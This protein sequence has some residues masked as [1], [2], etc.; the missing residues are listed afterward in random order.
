MKGMSGLDGLFLHLETPA[1]PMHV[2]A[3]Y[4]LEPPAG[5]VA[6][7]ADEL[8]RRL[9][10]RLAL[11]PF[12]RARLAPLPLHLANPLW[13]DGGIPDFARHLQRIVLPQPGGLAE[14]QDCAAALHATPLDRRHPLWELAIIDGLAG[15]EVAIYLKVHHA[16]VDGISGLG[17]AASIFDDSP[18]PS[19]VPVDWQ[20]LV[21][22]AERAGTGTRLLAALRQTAAQS[23][24]LLAQLPSGVRLLAGLVGRRG[25]RPTAGMRQN[26]G[27]GPRTPLNVPITAERDFAA[28]SLPL[29]GVR[30]IAERHA[31]TLNDVVLTLCSTAVR[32]YL[33]AHGGVPR[34][35]LLATMPVSLRDAGNTE[36]TI[37]A[38]LTLVRLATHVADPLRR[39]Q[40]VRAAAGAAKALTRHARAII[41]TDFPSLGVP[42]V[43]GGLASLYGRSRLAAHLTPLAN[44]AISNV[45]GPRQALY[46]A[47]GRVRACWPLSIVTHGLGLNI[48]VFS[49]CDA[50][51]FGLTVAPAAVPEVQ[52]LAKALRAAY[53]ELARLPTA[54]PAAEPAQRRA[55]RPAASTRSSPA[56]PA[57]TARG[58]TRRRSTTGGE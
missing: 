3:L 16:A 23:R 57:A 52:S 31:A 44:L 11:S 50:L 41:P 32:E 36:T 4:V 58:A 43:V 13:V 38:T 20:A 7:F 55:R 53:D 40:A 19:P 30:A 14:L 18:D 5:E 9:L 25:Q 8:E 28:V 42:W 37:Q 15:G 46:L 1:T 24:N 10:P 34:K 2:A 29:A 22:E 12:F 49:Y 45:P 47:G 54:P 6:G 26:L 39:L 51:D 56:T 33:A 17:L 48:T 35:S 21:G 27:F